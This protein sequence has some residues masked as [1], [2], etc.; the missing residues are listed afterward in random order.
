MRQAAA[1]VSLPRRL[2]SA[3]ELAEGL[4]LRHLLLLLSLGIVAVV[5]HSALDRDL[6]LPGHHGLEWM[7]LL[8]IARTNSRFRW[9]ATASCIGAATIS[10]LPFWGF[11]DPFMPLIYLL[12]GPIMDIGYRVAGRQQ[13]SLW[14]VAILGGLAFATKPV[15]RLA[16]S[17]VLG[18]PY[19]SLLYGFAFP[20]F[21][22]LMFGVLGASIGLGLVELAGR[23]KRVDPTR[24]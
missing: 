5:M 8:V 9:A 12:P 7:A 14:F 1:G 17:T 16:I 10:P 24:D 23:K 2:S 4:T 22:H 20:L 19:G 18:W 21:S 11:G 13:H 15:A 6:G 3:T